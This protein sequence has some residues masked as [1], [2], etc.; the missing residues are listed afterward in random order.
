[1]RTSGYTTDSGGTRVSA[2][3]AARAAAMWLVAAALA[4]LIPATPAGAQQELVLGTF[5]ANFEPG[6]IVYSDNLLALNGMQVTVVG[7]M[8]P[9]LKPR[10]N[11]FVLTR[12]PMITCPYCNDA[13]DWPDDIVM[14]YLSPGRNTDAEDHTRLI[15]V[16]GVLE[17][18]EFS[19]I[20]AG[21]SL[22]RVVEARVRRL[23]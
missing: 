11:W 19:D 10:T 2:P 17:I 6:G 9:P 13:A 20:E 22:V 21:L 3:V 14:V 23:N 16:T 18:G 8:A 4:V 7:Y 15:S 5:S 1:M 12:E